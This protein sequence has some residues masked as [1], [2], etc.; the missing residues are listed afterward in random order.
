[1]NANTHTFEQYVKLLS[2]DREYQQFSFVIKTEYQ[3]QKY[4]SSSNNLNFPS[5]IRR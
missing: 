2:Y 5:T 1:M 4:N 3:L